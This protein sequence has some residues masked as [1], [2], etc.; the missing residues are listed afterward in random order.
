MRRHL[1]VILALTACSRQSDSAS[2]ESRALAE[3]RGSYPDRVEPTGLV[4]TYDLVAEPAEVEL[5]D[6]R[7][8]KVWAYN[9]QVPGPTLRVRLGETLRV[10]FRNAL[11]QET[12]VHWHGV[13]VPN[14][15]DGVPNLTQPAVPPGGSFTYEYT[16]KDAGT[17][18]YHP[19]VRAS[20]QVERGLYGMLVVEDA[21]PPPY[22]ADETLILDD[23]RFGADG[24]I[25]AEFNT[26]HDLAMDGRWGGAIT[27]NARTDAV[28]RVQ[29]GSRLRLRFLNAANGRVF[30]PDF[31]DL[32]AKVIAVDGLYLRAPVPAVGFVVAPGNR[33]DVD[34]VFNQSTSLPLEIWDRFIPQRPNRLLRIDVAGDLVA[35]PTFAS[36][37]HA[38]VPAWSGALD[39]PTTHAF[40][41][42]AQQGG[43]FGIAWTIDGVAFA[44]HDHAA[45]GMAPMAPALTLQRDH[46]YRLQFVNESPRIHPIHLHG[47]FFRLLA[48]N[49]VAVDEPFFRDTVLV[50]ARETVDVGLVPTET[51]SWMMHCHILEHAEAGMMTTIAVR[52]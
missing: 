42:N 52:E 43:P 4:R 25:D 27:V 22:T 7:K 45:H 15:M 26:R 29:P 50:N 20:E 47:M 31:G 1:L 13:R 21:E 2:V 17:F 46:F 40:R 35:T 8:L 18:W 14:G 10:N 33:L 11:P 36:P 9:G 12:T 16:P 19:H 41:L 32:D 37:A 38:H 44:G 6:G 28:L 5:V 49:G 24:Q 3:F 34:V 30:A 51:G 23:W 48:R 39:A